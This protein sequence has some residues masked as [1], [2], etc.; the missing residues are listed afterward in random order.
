MRTCFADRPKIWANGEFRMHQRD[1]LYQSYL[2]AYA[3]AKEAGDVPLFLAQ[4]LLIWLDHFPAGLYSG[5]F[6]DVD[7]DADLART[8]TVS[9]FISRI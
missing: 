8:K 6:A 3:K 4:F 7:C 1:R 9:G 5:P 2:F